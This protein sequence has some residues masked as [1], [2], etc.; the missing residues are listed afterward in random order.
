M[1]RVNLTCQALLACLGVPALPAMGISWDG[2]GD[3]STWN[4]PI[5][6]LGNVM[7][8]STDTATIGD[9]AAI[10]NAFLHLNM[11]DTLA[12]LSLYDGMRLDTNGFSLLVNGDTLLSGYNVVDQGGINVGYS[13]GLNI[14]RGAGADDFDTNNLTLQNEASVS[15]WGGAILEVDNVLSVSD[16][17]RISGHGVIRLVQG[18]GTVYVNNGSLDPRTEGMTVNV[19]GTG[20]IDLDGTSGTGSVHASASKIDG[21]GFDHLTINGKGL[22]DAFDGEMDTTANGFVTMNLADGW[23]LG[24]GGL[25]RMY[26]NTSHP[27]TAEIRGA[28]LT[29]YGGVYV[30]AGDAHGRFTANVA[31]MNGSDFEVSTDDTLTFDGANNSFTGATF[32]IAQGGVVNFNNATTVQSA[33]FNFAN[34]ADGR[35]EFNGPTTFSYNTTINSNGLLVQDGTATV[36]GTMTV[37]GGRF[38]LDGNPGTST[39]NLGNGANPGSMILNVDG[40]DTTNN[41][42]D[43]TINTANAGLTGRLE[44]NL[45]G[46][47]FWTM[48]GTLNL[49]GTN[50]LFN[51]TR[52][53]GSRMIVSGTV[54]VANDKPANISADTDFA[55]MSTINMVGPASRLSVSGNTRVYSG[56]T[57]NGAGTLRN[58]GTLQLRNGVDLEDVKLINAGTL[59]VG[60]SPGT[61]TV[62]DFEQTASG[63][64]EVEM[65]G[66]NPGTGH[67]RLNVAGNA[68]LDGRIA[69][70][71]IN[72]Y[73]P[74]LYTPLTLL[75]S[76]NRSGIFSTVGGIAYA[77]GLGLAV[78]YSATDVLVTPALHGDIDF[79]G[80]VDDADFGL[81]FAGF[82][83][84]MGS[85]GGSQWIHGDFD[86]DGDTDDSDFGIAFAN[87]T[88]PGGAV[89]VPEPG[90][91]ALMAIGGLMVARRR[92]G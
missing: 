37:N 14:D 7:P 11:N 35:V 55:S 65:G 63:I 41:S 77:P 30:G 23:T 69:L 71:V 64:W 78:T 38:D 80:D 79:D 48:A 21:S 88:V 20:L 81:A 44:V 56:A 22:T 72:G 51:P 9:L 75:S 70:E 27:G 66:A 62:P 34:P 39:I 2:N 3:G 13:S 18:S 76:F 36:L 54:N 24:A 50:S 29:I 33:T 4:D 49:A 82:T 45:P 86:G 74:V 10:E 28:D 8:S 47:D 32:A 43:G 58:A 60:N 61:A 92:R 42:F 53:A 73:N 17:S 1:K 31:A 12:G 25:I 84:P 85:A 89:M 40:I 26:G 59:R 91:L 83:G 16:G 46:N 15:L 67:D 6:W 68:D 90:C 87:F 52:V 19:S 57:F 5:N